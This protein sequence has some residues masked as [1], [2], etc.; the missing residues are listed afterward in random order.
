MSQKGRTTAPHTESAQRHLHEDVISVP[1]S[2]SNIK[3]KA[4]K[5]A[6]KTHLLAQ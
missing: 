1:L 5:G 2:R 3:T 6:T 4:N